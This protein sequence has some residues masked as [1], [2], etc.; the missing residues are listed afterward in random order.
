[1]R[2]ALLVAGLTGAISI[3]AL[4]GCEK[5]NKDGVEKIKTI[6]LD[7]GAEPKFVLEYRI[8]EGSKQTLDMVLDMTMN[9]SGAGMPGGGDIILPR[10]IMVTDI[11]IPKVGKDGEMEMVMTTTDVLL[12]DRP[13]VMPGVSSAMEGEMDGIT[14]MRM[15]ATLLPNGQTRNMKVDGA[16]VSAKVL[17]QMKQTEQMVDQM[18]T[19]L[20]DVPVG[21]GARWRVE[22]TVKQQGMRMN[23]VATYE[24]LE[25]HEGGAVIKSDIEMSAPEQTIDQGGVKVKLDSMNGVGEATCTLDFTRMVESVEAAIDM[26]MSMSAMGQVVGAD[27]SMQMQIVPKGQTVKPPRVVGYGD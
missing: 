9:M 18:T 6:V 23:L 20:P 16:S 26:N 24:V 1:M 7:E 5:A 22:Q 3:G 13:G 27:M 25:V 11:E 2:N 8:P 17:E 15:T 19:I 4:G 10:I 21:Q 12:E 14:G